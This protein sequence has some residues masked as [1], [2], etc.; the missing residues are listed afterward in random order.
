MP[1]S[2]GEHFCDMGAVRDQEPLFGAVASDGSAWRMIAVI[3]R[4]PS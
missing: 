3:A 4:D 1:A 2:G